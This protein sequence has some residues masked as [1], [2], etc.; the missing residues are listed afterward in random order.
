[1]QISSPPSQFNN[2]EL[3]IWLRQLYSTL[4]NQPMSEE[5][6]ATSTSEGVKGTIAYDDNY[7]YICYQN[8]LWKRISLV[9]F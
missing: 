2:P 3:D 1:M 8:N 9:A 7:V 5:A 4:I 6:P